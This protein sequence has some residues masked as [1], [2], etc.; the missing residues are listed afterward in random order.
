[1][2][3]DHS[4]FMSNNVRELLKEMSSKVKCTFL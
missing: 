1:M 3:P 4:S 2:N